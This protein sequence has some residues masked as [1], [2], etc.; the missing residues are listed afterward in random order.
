MNIILLGPPGAGKGTQAARLK[1]SQNLLHLSTGDMLR[2]AVSEGT[3]AGLEAK[4]G[5]E[6]GELVS[7]AIVM[8]IVSERLDQDD[9]KQGVILDGVPRNLE[10][11]EI[12]TK[13]LADKGLKIDSVILIV[14]D[15]DALVKRIAGRFSCAKC[16][17]GYHYEFQKPAKEGVCDDCG[18]T[19]FSRRADDNEETVRNRLNVYNEQTA[20][21]VEFYEKQGLVKKI[22]GMADIDDVTRQIESAL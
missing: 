3:P 18:G 17:A 2:G 16:G 20:P 21:V 1:K 4:K 14:A 5:M 8:G 12:L 10:Q 13:D 9:V 6:K 7:D 22:D 15:D 11:A 19:E